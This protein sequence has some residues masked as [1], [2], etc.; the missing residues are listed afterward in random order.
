MQT[1]LE[2][3]HTTNHFRDCAKMLTLHVKYCNG[4]MI[5]FI[6]RSQCSDAFHLAKFSHR[7][8]SE[9]SKSQSVSVFRLNTK[10]THVSIFL[11]VEMGQLSAN[12]HAGKHKER[13]SLSRGERD[14]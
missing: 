11:F 12:Y 1:L 10:K 9:L 13:L 2:I 14:M 6:W 4:M 8:L 7:F 3:D 5:I